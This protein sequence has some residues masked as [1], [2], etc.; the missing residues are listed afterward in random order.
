[1]YSGFHWYWL[2]PQMAPHPWQTVFVAMTFVRSLL[3]LL[4]VAWFTLAGH[5]EIR[6]SE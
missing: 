3:L 1:V 2:S 4:V 6:S 5:D